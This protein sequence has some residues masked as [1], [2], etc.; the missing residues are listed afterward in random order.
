[1]LGGHCWVMAKQHGHVHCLP[2][3]LGEDAKIGP[4]GQASLSVPMASFD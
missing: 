3:P 2:L 1:M 4:Y